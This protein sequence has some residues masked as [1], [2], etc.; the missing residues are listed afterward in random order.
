MRAI[1]IIVLLLLVA[2]V[3]LGFYRDWFHFT[4]E[5]S[6]EDGKEAVRLEVN[7]DKIQQDLNK[8]KQ[9]AG[10]IGAEVKDKLSVHSTTETAKGAI[11]K[12]EDANHH[13][14]LRTSEQKEL[15][16]QVEPTSRIR[17]RDTQIQLQDLRVGDQVTVTYQV[18]E[19]KNIAQ[20]VTV[21]RAT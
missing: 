17:L 21:E 2:L 18:K 19:G 5:Q 13:F 15:T 11:T 4:R 14:L 1:R 16:I 20:T 8:A 6:P 9:Q 12:V 7:K 10:K 3:G